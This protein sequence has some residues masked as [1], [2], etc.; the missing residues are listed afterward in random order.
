VLVDAERLD[1]RQPVG[2]VGPPAGFDL[3]RV[4]QRVPVDP[5]P[6]GQRGDGGV[7]VGQRVRRP[8]HRAAGEQRPRRRQ[9]VRLGERHH[10]ARRLQATPHPLAPRHP[11][12]AMAERRV[13]QQML[14]PAV[15]HRQHAAV[16]TPLD[17]P[18]TVP[19]SVDTVFGGRP[20]RRE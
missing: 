1:T 20:I 19:A 15:R 14:P 17:L 11:D 10:R 18:W 7:V 16:V 6:T 12:A 5:K 3:E 2:I 9:G 4:P 8:G 13:V